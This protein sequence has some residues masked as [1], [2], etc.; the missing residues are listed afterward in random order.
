MV[1]DGNK[2]HA[3]VLER[4]HDS[5][6]RLFSIRKNT[7]DMKHT[8]HSL[9]T[10]SI[11]ADTG[12]VIGL[13]TGDHESFVPELEKQQRPDFLISR[14]LTLLLPPNNLLDRLLVEEV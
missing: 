10:L 12:D 11:G 3:G 5:F 6:K 2:I 14:K 9:C 4:L 7:V 13:H 8:A 1:T